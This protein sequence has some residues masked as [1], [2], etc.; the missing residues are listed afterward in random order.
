MHILILA[1]A[2]PMP[3][4][5]T[6][7]GRV[8]AHLCQALVDGGHQVT[9]MA[10][11]Y[12]QKTQ[13]PYPWAMLTTKQSDP[14]GNDQLVK[15]IKRF[16]PD[17][18]L[19]FNDIWVCNRWFSILWATCKNLEIPQI[20]FLGYFPVDC[21]G[22]ESELTR[23]LPHW[24]GV[25]TYSQFGLGVL[26]ASGYSGDCA[27]IPHGI[28]PRVN[29][30]PM[31]GLLPEPLQ[32]SWIV[33]RTDINRSRKRY[34]LTI[35]A[36]CEFAMDKPLP[37]APGAPILWLHCADYGDDLPVREY[38][39]RTLAKTGH[40]F[41]QRP[42]LRSQTSG[43]NQHP[44]CSEADLGAIYATADCYLQT[45]DAEGWGLCPV[46]ASLQGA[47]IIVG[48][49]SIHQDLWQDCAFM[50]DPIDHRSETFG[51]LQIDQHGSI[52]QVRTALEYPVVSSHDYAKALE[53]AYS[54]P[55]QAEQYRQNA[56]AQWQSSRF[57]WPVIEQQFR[58]WVARAL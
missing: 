26:Q 30:S 55:A 16:R 22:Y 44:F 57:Q 15:L 49:H 50:V 31:R 29:V 43:H 28:E 56:L 42:M 9:Q 24:A 17:A 34:D 25:A 47:S 18:V 53:L 52:Q 5:T 11:N 13:H 12:P 41:N 46:E 3:G 20:P 39:E 4:L 19:G 21:A 10:I 14:L 8:A 32:Q 36:F 48:N 35:Q 27:I 54:Q 2:P 6:G 45:S 38:Y 1:D 33:L 7:F 40:T 58:D 51:L 23:L 37:P